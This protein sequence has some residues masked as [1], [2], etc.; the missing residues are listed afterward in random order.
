MAKVKLNSTFNPF[1]GSIAKFVF[2]QTEHGTVVTP[3]P[4]KPE[5][6]SANH[7]AHG[8]RFAVLVAPPCPPAPESDGRDGGD[9]GAARQGQSADC[10]VC[11]AR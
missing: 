11:Y 10:K 3:E 1:S 5:T 9:A 2:E 7:D 4:D 6:W 8:E